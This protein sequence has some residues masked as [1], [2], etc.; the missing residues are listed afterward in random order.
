MINWKHS[1]GQAKKTMPYFIKRLTLFISALDSRETNFFHKSKGNR[2]MSAVS[3]KN[4]GERHRLTSSIGKGL[5]VERKAELWKA[6]E[7]GI[8]QSKRKD[9]LKVSFRKS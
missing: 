7:S 5:S 9:D 6:L 2:D 1:P 4:V 8:V 3:A